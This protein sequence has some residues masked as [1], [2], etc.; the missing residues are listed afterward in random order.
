LAIPYTNN[1]YQRLHS[2][3]DLDPIHYNHQQKTIFDVMDPNVKLLFEEGFKQVLAKIK[4]G[5]I[6]HEA[7]FTKSLKEVASADR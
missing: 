3:D 4:E 6:I 2:C 7:A 1:W 5:F